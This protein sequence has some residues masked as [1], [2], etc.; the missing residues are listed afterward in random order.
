VC[1]SSGLPRSSFRSKIRLTH[2]PAQSDE[3]SP[4]SQRSYCRCLRPS[5]RN[6]LA[7]VKSSKFSRL[8]L[9]CSGNVKDF[10]WGMGNLEEI[11]E[12]ANGSRLWA[13]CSPPPL[14]PNAL[15]AVPA[16]HVTTPSTS[17][18]EKP[19]ELLAASLQISP[20]LRITAPAA[21]SVDQSC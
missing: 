15:P 8:F 17:C 12:T 14:K 2:N 6:R 7:K 4:W 11:E 20:D 10:A 3:T 5:I 13:S 19:P 9:M 1:R 16:G 21:I 18:K